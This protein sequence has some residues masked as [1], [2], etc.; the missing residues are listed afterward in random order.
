MPWLLLAASRFGMSQPLVEAR[1]ASL[2]VP[3]R[4]CLTC[5]PAILL[6]TT[7]VYSQRRLRMRIFAEPDDGL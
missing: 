6:L 2:L 7:R 4:L 3:T 1:V 5:L